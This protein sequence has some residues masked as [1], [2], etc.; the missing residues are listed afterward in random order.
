MRLQPREAT[1][2]GKVYCTLIGDLI[3]NGVCN[4]FQA[5]LIKMMP[6]DE[7]FR[8]VIKAQH[9]YQSANKVYSGNFIEVVHEYLLIWK[10]KPKTYWDV[11]IEITGNADNFIAS[12]WRNII[13]V[14]MMKTR[15]A[16]LGMIYLEVSKIAVHQIAANQHWKAKIRQILQ[17]YHNQVGVTREFGKYPT[18]SQLNPT[19]IGFG[20][21]NTFRPSLSYYGV[22]D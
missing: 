3:K 19:Y 11:C 2:N 12:S 8:V 1:E 17:K 6:R 21:I 13:R 22:L 15:K 5:D 7:L 18:L 20:K 14:V 4:S 16:S 10:K 9:N